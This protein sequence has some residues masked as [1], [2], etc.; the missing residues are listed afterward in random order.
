M[1]YDLII[2]VLP[3]LLGQTKVKKMDRQEKIDKKVSH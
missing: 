3:V 1:G 2:K